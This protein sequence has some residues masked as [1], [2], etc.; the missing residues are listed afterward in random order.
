MTRDI[1]IRTKS[2]VR[3]YVLGR[4]ARPQT[5]I[6][7]HL[8]WTDD[9]VMVSDK[10]SNHQF[11]MYDIEKTQPYWGGLVNPD[12]MMAYTDI[13]KQSGKNQA[14]SGV[15]LLNSI[16]PMLIVYGIVGIV[17]IYAVLTGGVVKW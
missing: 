10:A 12:L 15:K 7:K 5:V 2:E 9:D 17:I 16:D 1:Y 8:Y 14:V 3:R 6:R 4:Q 11:V 13:A